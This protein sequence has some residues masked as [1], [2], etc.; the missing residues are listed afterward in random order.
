M[1]MQIE[2]NKGTCDKRSNHDQEIDIKCSK[3]R[4]YKMESKERDDFF[5]TKRNQLMQGFLGCVR[6]FEIYPKVARE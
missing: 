6:A 5:L 3:P 1:R 4:K 2:S